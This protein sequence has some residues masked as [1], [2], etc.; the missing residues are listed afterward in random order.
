MPRNPRHDQIL[1][2]LQNFR[3][4][5][6]AELTERLGVS[7]VTIRKDLNQLES[8]GYVLRSHGGVRLAQ[9]V[10]S[11]SNFT[12]RKSS[13][14]DLKDRITD[15]ALKLIQ[16]GDTLCLDAGTTN[17]M[18]A[19]KLINYSVRVVTNSLEVINILKESESVA[20][21]ILGGNFRQEAGSFIGPVTESDISQMQFDL[22]FIG[23]ESISP[24]GSFLTG[25]SIEGAVK[26]AILNA[27]KRRIILADSSKYEARAFARFAD[28]D[29]V[30]ILIS[31]TGFKEPDF[32]KELGIELLLV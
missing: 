5:S 12:S 24:T 30:D 23:A 16:D 18:L 1:N 17:A 8:M 14:H 2:L 9:S 10:S 13:N 31:D 27:S 20:L 32:F 19:E 3:H 6:V 25:N 26:R 15:Q 28:S 22:S 21:T 7:N 11:V 4:I 29:M